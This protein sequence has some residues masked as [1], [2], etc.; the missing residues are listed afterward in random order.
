MF[1]DFI[2]SMEFVVTRGCLMGDNNTEDG[3]IDHDNLCL[4]LK[5]FVFSTSL[6]MLVHN[7]NL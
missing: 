5:V 1:A 6:Q 7:I 2:A 3:E 4:N